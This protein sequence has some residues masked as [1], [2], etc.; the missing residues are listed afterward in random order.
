MNFKQPFQLLNSILLINTPKL[1]EEFLAHPEFND[2]SKIDS[3]RLISTSSIK[4]YLGDEKLSGNLLCDL[5]M[6]LW[7]DPNMILRF[8]DLQERD[9]ELRA[10]Y[11]QHISILF[12]TQT[13]Y[14][15][16]LKVE[17]PECIS[18]LDLWKEEILS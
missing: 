11:R 12:K 8:Y 1:V 3:S 15:D 7:G 4:Q 2:Y 5:L 9:F 6:Y 18:I 14:F 17:L 10:S 13:L 16:H